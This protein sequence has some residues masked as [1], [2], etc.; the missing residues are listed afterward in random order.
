MTPSI[1]GLVL[2]SGGSLGFSFF[3]DS[4]KILLK[5]N[6]GRCIMTIACSFIVFGGRKIS[7][8]VGFWVHFIAVRIFQNLA[9]SCIL[10]IGRMV[11]SK[12]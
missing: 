7:L 9:F 4:P 5:E 12:G 1:L 3:S 2:G 8:G 10:E 11:S 6:R